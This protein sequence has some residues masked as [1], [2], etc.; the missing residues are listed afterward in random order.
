MPT[1]WKVLMYA[2]NTFCW[3]ERAGA[4]FLLLS[5]EVSNHVHVMEGA[6]R[7][8]TEFGLLEVAPSEI[9]VIGRGMRFAVELLPGPSPDAASPSRPNSMDS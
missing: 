8:L 9:A 4:L 5:D 7:I 6:L 1:S 3:Q 2:T